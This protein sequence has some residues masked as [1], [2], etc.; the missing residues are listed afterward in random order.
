[1]DFI[2]AP[3]KQE[4]SLMKQTRHVKH[5]SSFLKSMDPI[6]QT[7]MRASAD[8]CGRDSAHCSLQMV[9]GV[10]T[11]DCPP[12]LAHAETSEASLY[13][14]ATLYRFGLPMD[15]AKLDD[16]ALPE[17]C[18]CY[19]APLWDPG[20]QSIRADRIFIWQCHLG[21]CGED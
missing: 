7:L 14:A 9:R 1:L 10:A 6:N 4:V 19:N 20:M 18:S 21:R 5:A 2:T 17:T 3:C 11:M 12:A 15:Y 8:Q 16:V 13:C